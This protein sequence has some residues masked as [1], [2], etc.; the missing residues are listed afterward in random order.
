M[1]G[2]TGWGVA[3]VKF[4]DLAPMMP[5]LIVAITGL[6]VLLA[7]AFTPKGRA[8]P[9]VPLS[10][11]GLVAAVSEVIRTLNGPQRGAVLGGSVAAD[12]FALFLHLLI[13][14]VGSLALLLAPITS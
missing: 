3:E 9:S 5:A 7:Q 12:D 4:A 1:W 14:R 6:L 11:A 10:L 2:G 13:L 8:S